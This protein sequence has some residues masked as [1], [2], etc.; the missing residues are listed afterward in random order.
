MKKTRSSAGITLIGH[1][2]LRPGWC[3]DS[4]H[5]SSTPVPYRDSQ[6]S[7]SLMCGPLL[8]LHARLR[9]MWVCTRT[10][11]LARTIPRPI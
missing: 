7:A 11:T 4:A 9:V 1:R 3:A 2:H 10:I 8:P 5:S 6:R